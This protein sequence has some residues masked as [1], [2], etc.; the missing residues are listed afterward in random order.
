MSGGR[1]AVF[2]I[3]VFLLGFLAGIYVEHSVG[4]P[5]IGERKIWSIGIYVGSS[6]L[7]LKPP[8]G[9]VNPVLTSRDVTDREAEFVADP[10]MVRENSTWYMFF[11]VVDS[12][13]G[14]G[15]IGLAMSRD[16]FHWKYVKIVLDE[17][18]HLSYPYVFKWRNHYYM[19]PESGDACE[20]RLYQ[21]SEFPAKWIYVKTLLHGCYRDPSIFHYNGTWWIYVYEERG[22]LRL[23]Y[24]EN[25]TGPWIEHPESPIV[26]C[27]LH[28]ARPGG[29][30]I[31]LGGKV[32]R[33]AQDD[34][35]GYGKAV[36][37]F[38]VLVLSEME[39]VE[40]ELSESPVLKPSGSGWN[41]DGMHNLDAHM[42]DNGKWIACVDGYEKEVVFGPRY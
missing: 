8:E 10:F 25:L 14:Q 20:V 32:I 42:T 23:F 13:T 18:F 15:D 35:A 21:A 19:I 31:V 24:S 38:E 39:Y 3:I 40:R 30:V 2:L 7:G 26:R 34:Y 41:S 6:P 37:A 12:E 16:G 4:I 36:R 17:P 22:V 29:R 27:N 9:N 1:T 11:E 33:F 5:F 28:S